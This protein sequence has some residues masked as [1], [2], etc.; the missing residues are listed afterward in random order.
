MKQKICKASSLAKKRLIYYFSAQRPI[1]FW[2]IVTLSPPVCA[3]SLCLR[4]A[5]PGLL[6]VFTITKVRVLSSFGAKTRA[7]WPGRVSRL[8]YTATTQLWCGARPGGWDQQ[9]ST[10]LDLARYI[11]GTQ[12]RKPRSMSTVPATQVWCPQTSSHIIPVLI[13]P[14]WLSVNPQ[15]NTAPTW[16]R[17]QNLGNL[18]I[19]KCPRWIFHYGLSGPSCTLRHCSIRAPPCL[20]PALVITNMRNLKQK[21]P[22]VDEPVKILAWWNSQA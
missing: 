10:G 9:K 2:T 5:P 17:Q 12:A 21:I 14:K 18:L 6:R 11:F 13:W 8:V 20:N 4:R 7:L 16:E 15:I 3:W 19:L 1:L 22:G